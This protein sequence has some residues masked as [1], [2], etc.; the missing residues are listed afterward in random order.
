MLEPIYKKRTRL[1]KSKVDCPCSKWT[2]HEGLNKR[3]NRPTVYFGPC[4]S[5]WLQRPSIIDHFGTIV[6]SHPFGP[7]TSNLTQ[8]FVLLIYFGMNWDELTCNKMKDH[9]DFGIDVWVASERENDL[10]SESKPGHNQP[11][12]HHGP[13]LKIII[14]KNTRTNRKSPF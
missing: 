6:Q 9:N 3:F 7:F 14:W 12:H 13:T 2:I 1:T 10:I 4:S 8:N 11:E 5:K